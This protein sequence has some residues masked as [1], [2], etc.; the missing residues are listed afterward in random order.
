MF[1]DPFADSAD[2]EA[3]H[4]FPNKDLLIASPHENGIDPRNTELIER[5]VF[6][7]HPN[8]PLSCS[9]SHSFCPDDLAFRRQRGVFM[10]I[11]IICSWLS[12]LLFSDDL[13]NA[14]DTI[15]GHYYS[16]KVVNACDH[17]N[18]WNFSPCI[19]II[20]SP[21]LNGLA[22]FS[23]LLS[24]Y[25]VSTS[26]SSSF[27]FSNLSIRLKSERQLVVFFTIFCLILFLIGMTVWRST[28]V[29]FEEGFIRAIFD[30]CQIVC[31]SGLLVSAG[32]LSNKKCFSSLSKNKH[33]PTFSRQLVI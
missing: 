6:V 8:T 12:F 17:Q 29:R 4:F 2:A 19:V 21:I 25:L 14:A 22:I 18:Y 32:M 11:L 3:E 24:A 5:E 7:I 10:I 23:L 15:S 1:D 13:L 20:L 26:V 16:N 30:Y 28:F 31:L 33:S 9:S 27:S